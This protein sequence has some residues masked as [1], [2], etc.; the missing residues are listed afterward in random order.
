MSGIVVGFAG[1]THLGINSA[2]ATAAHGFA[3]VGYD[4][5]PVLIERLSRQTM[6]ISE[7]GLDDLVTAHADR[8]DFTG[9]VRRLAACYVVYIA[10]DVPTNDAGESDLVPIRAL[11]DR[12]SAA[13]RHDAVL[14]I[15]CQVPP[16]F[17]RALTAVEP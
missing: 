2:A 11:I 3:V 5:D 8:L 16:G 4:E 17:T 10:A 9:D 6:P 15:L 13:L 12:V 7:P 1:M 14:V